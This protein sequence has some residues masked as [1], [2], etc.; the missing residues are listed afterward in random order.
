MNNFR[1]SFL[2]NFEVPKAVSDDSGSMFDE[3][4]FAELQ[5]EAAEKLVKEYNLE[6]KA[7]RAA[8]R[9]SRADSPGHRDHSRSHRDDRHRDSRSRYDSYSRSSGRADHDRRESR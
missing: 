7:S 4:I 3:V 2:A 9:R 8:E 5:R 6:G 1:Y